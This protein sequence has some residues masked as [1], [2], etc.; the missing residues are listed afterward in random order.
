MFEAPRGGAGLSRLLAQDLADE[1]LSVYSGPDEHR[2]SGIIV[3]SRQRSSIALHRRQRY[4]FFESSVGRS[5][6]PERSPRGPRFHGMRSGAEGTRHTL[7]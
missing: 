2:E 4:Y 7:G 5:E 1:P 6:V 3:S